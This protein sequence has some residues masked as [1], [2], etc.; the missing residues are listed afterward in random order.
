MR[1]LMLLLTLLTAG[2]SSWPDSGTGGG[3]QLYVI[4]E[5]T[6]LSA[7]KHKR[8]A[9]LLAQNEVLD[10]Q[11]QLL[12]VQGAQRCI[13]AAVVQLQ[14]QGL[15]V[16]RQLGGS[17][18][19]DASTDL[20]AYQH[21]IRQVQWRFDNI[22]QQT[23]CSVPAPIQNLAPMP[24]T[25]NVHSIGLFT[26]LFDHDSAEIGPGYFRHLELVAQ[27]LQQCQCELL[28]VGHTDQQGN[29]QSNQTLSVRRV[30]AVET[31]LQ[32]FGITNIKRLANGEQ[33]PLLRQSADQ[34]LNRRVDLLVRP[35]EQT[36]M[37]TAE[38]DAVLLLRH[39]NDAGVAVK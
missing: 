21:M 24:V 25:T 35:L 33:E 29:E 10:A 17:L 3:D 28:L 2:C 20:A 39:W 15:K 26:V 36:S 13:P 1:R 5:P 32:R 6:Y 7:I 34:P 38:S 37:A 27:L 16:R 12:I 11:T 22:R 18:F 9:A 19:T 31:I 8:Y 4:A 30:D 23:Q 14:Q